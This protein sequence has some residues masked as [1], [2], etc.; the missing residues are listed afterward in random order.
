MIGSASASPTSTPPPPVRLYNTVPPPPSPPPALLASFDTEAAFSHAE[1]GHPWAAGLGSN[2]RAGIVA[3][4][5]HGTAVYLYGVLSGL[6]PGAWV[7]ASVLSTC[8]ATSPVNSSRTAIVGADGSV[9][10]EARQA[11]DT[12]TE[13]AL[14]EASALSLA[15]TGYLAIDQTADP[16]QGMIGGRLFCSQLVSEPH[17]Q[18][19]LVG[20]MPAQ[21][22]ERT[23]R[24]LVVLMRKAHLASSKL[25]VRGLVSGLEP[26]FHGMWHFHRGFNCLGATED[27]TFYEGVYAGYR[28]ARSSV[29]GG[30]GWTYGNYKADDRGVALLSWTFGLDSPDMISVMS[31][32]MSSGVPAEEADDTCGGEMPATLVGRQMIFHGRDGIYL[33]CGTVAGYMPGVT[34]ALGRMT[35]YQPTAADSDVHSL[36]HVKAFVNREAGEEQPASRLELTATFTGLPPSANLRFSQHAGFE[37]P[38]EDAVLATL[39]S[40]RDRPDPRTIQTGDA[41][42]TVPMA[43]DAFGNALLSASINGTMSYIAGRVV[44]A[45]TEDGVALACGTIEPTSA[46]VRPIAPQPASG[47]KGGLLVASQASSGV[48]LRGKLLFESSSPNGTLSIGDHLVHLRFTGSHGALE[49]RHHTLGPDARITPSATLRADA[50]SSTLSEAALRGESVRLAIDNGAQ[51]DVGI[52]SGPVSEVPTPR[53]GLCDP[54]LNSGLRGVEVGFFALG[55]V[56]ATLLLALVVLL[57]QDWAEKATV[58]GTRAMTNVA[59]KAKDVTAT[60]TE[61]MAKLAAS[62]KAKVAYVLTQ[63]KVVK[64]MDSLE[65]GAMN[66]RPMQC[67]SFRPQVRPFAHLST[68]ARKPRLLALHGAGSNQGVTKRQLK[69]LGIDEDLFEIF[70]LHGPL[71]SDSAGLGL[72][73]SVVNGP[74]YTWYNQNTTEEEMLRTLSKV[75]SAIAKHKVDGVFGFSQ[76]A[77]VLSACLQP[78]VMT[79][80]TQ[81]TAHETSV[82]TRITDLFESSRRSP[83]RQASSRRP[84]ESSRHPRNAARE[85]TSRE[86]S[87]GLRATSR[88]AASPSREGSVGAAQNQLQSLDFVLLAHATHTTDI[89]QALYLSADAPKSAIATRSLHIIGTSDEFKA[90]SEDSAL[91]FEGG[92]KRMVLYH[93]AGHELPRELTTNEVF[94]HRFMSHIEAALAHHASEL[95]ARE[96]SDKSVRRPKKLPSLPAEYARLPGAT[97]SLTI[98]DEDGK[99]VDARY[100]IRPSPPETLKPEEVS[101]LSSAAIS[102][103]QQLVRVSLDPSVEASPQTIRGLLAAQPAGQP[104]L[105]AASDPSAALSYGQLLSFMSPGGA[106]DLSVLGV[107]PCD[108]VVYVVPGGVIAAV[109]FL[110][111]AAQATAAPLDPTIVQNDAFDALE[112]FS[113]KHVILFQGAPHDAV[114]GAVEQAK[115]DEVR[116]AIRIHYATPDDEAGPGL[117]KLTPAA[118]STPSKAKLATDATDVALLLRTSGTTSKPKGVPLQQ[119]AIVRNALL[120]SSTIEITKGDICLNAMPLFHIG[121]LS[122][123]ILAS[124]AVGSS[125]T[126]LD[127]FSAEK[128]YNALGAGPQP[129]W[130]SAVPTIHM[131]VVNYIKDNGIAPVHSLRFI[132]SGAAAL[133]PTDGQALSKCYGGVPIH[134]TYSM[135]EQ[136]PISQPNVGLDQLN[137]KNGSVGIAIAASMAIVDPTT[138]AP[139][140]PGLR[141][142]I[143]I[144]GPTV[145]RNYLNNPK[146]DMEN[147]FLLSCAD[148]TLAAESDRFFLTGDVGVLDEDGHLTIKGRSKEL[149]KRG[150]E[151]VSPYEV[152]D[153]VKK[154]LRWVRMPVVFAVPSPAWGEEVGCVIILEPTAPQEVADDLKLLLKE[155]RGACRSHGLAPN[156]WPSV[157]QVITWE[158]LP[159]TK[160]NKPIRNGLAEKLGIQ[161]NN[162]EE[163][164]AAPVKQ[165]PPKVSRAVEGVRFVLACQVV[166]NHVGLQAPGGGTNMDIHSPDS[167]GAFGQARFMCIHVPTFFALAGFG[168]AANMGPAPRSKLG[169]IAARLSP[170]YPMYLVSLALLLINQV[171][172]CHPGN[173]EST[174]HWLA[175]W[176]DSTRGDFCE[177]APLLSGWWGSLFATIAIYVLGLQSWPMYLFSWFLSYYTWFSSVYYAMVWSQPYFY[178]PMIAIRGRIKLIWSVTIII[179]LLNLCVVA[180]WLLGSFDDRTYDGR[181]SATMLGA[182]DKEAEWTGQFS[183]MYYLF[184]PFWWPSFAL[185]TC[186]AFLFDYYRPYES[187]HAWVWGVITD[188]ISA[189]LVLTGYI[190]Y[191]LLA[192]C[193]QK[194]G[195]LCALV[196]PNPSTFAID[197]RGLDSHLILAENDNLGIRSVAG[198]WSRFLMPIMVLWLFG[199]AVGKGFTAKLFEKSFF[200]ETLAPV[201]YNLYLFHQWVGQM[202]YLVTR[203]QWW[204]YWRYRKAFFWFSPL[205][206]PVAWWEY[207]YVVILTTFFGMFMAK[208][209]P[210][211]ISR[212]EAGRAYLK[213][214]LCRGRSNDTRELTT[215]E[216]V[217]NEIEQLTGAAVEPDWTLAECGLASVAGPVVVNRLQVA[218]PGVTISLAD[219][220][221]VDTVGGLAELLERRL[222][223]SKNNGVGSMLAPNFGKTGV[224]VAAQI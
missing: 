2:Q 65:L 15:N 167:W 58:S 18:L 217:L 212:W 138:L 169:F 81:S 38:G 62:T 160:T 16:I 156:K 190:L 211:M 21:F 92:E 88:R 85:T 23:A 45:A 131:A 99:E 220:I 70:Y 183:L 148:G 221:D 32:E 182:R 117:F 31:R 101:R 202:Y 19:A 66:S 84:E 170:M 6:T 134:G 178:A 140:P 109:A 139:Q 108:S 137:Q 166:F 157:A 63:V 107:Q 136:M 150:G 151:Q 123:S 181:L 186:A 27:I 78:D 119:G 42:V 106:G 172:M 223:E 200:V 39:Y 55:L 86:T 40:P 22:A 120:L 110:T 161:P 64:G 25:T 82:R 35:V 60:G 204:S 192:S 207:F 175:Q 37:C 47:L 51:M 50:Y 193:V 122:A 203:Q 191:P 93:P 73:E 48:S 145:M 71:K 147:Y 129:T 54:N 184:P 188:A 46:L 214:F 34:E 111:V 174:F 222:A 142:V 118:G 154:A 76:G 69:N 87:R 213:S 74:F 112:Q 199:L 28:T 216:V 224:L 83:H 144:S 56:A 121:G 68:T 163:Q 5:A 79:L 77:A 185:G 94:H 152:E 11:A 195:L 219:L 75:V 196:D 180:G 103:T 165:G 36:V 91:V 105:R 10:L 67:Q 208:L 198:I 149:I 14:T 89:R 80:L 72:T 158:E 52:L 194:E 3:A 33:G 153:A 132:R 98:R 53:D 177:P 176:D 162:V 96:A 130:Y 20:R 173:F 49:L 30:D 155:V 102:K 44:I 146:A 100:L 125:C 95:V 41:V 210:Y 12:T 43:S 187:H 135:S 24:G 104:C 197:D 4:Q 168:M 9:V 17:T 1:L 61:A 164:L 114:I 116:P 171:A 215:T 179:V 59:A 90:R 8:E 133:T 205:P 206:V 126:C 113:A 201:S 218:V 141:G 127:S 189:L 159:K 7:Q 209:D 13:A 29:R 57:K 97:V 26:S 143:A 124:L 128:F 115:A